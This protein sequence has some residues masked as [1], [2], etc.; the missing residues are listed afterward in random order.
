[1]TAPTPTGTVITTLEHMRALSPN[2][3]VVD[4]D[5]DPWQFDDYTL[6]AQPP[7]HGCTSVDF[8]ERYGPFI[9][10]YVPGRPAPRPS[11]LVAADAMRAALSVLE[12]YAMRMDTA[13][14]HRCNCN[15]FSNA[16]SAVSGVA[17]RLAA[18]ATTNDDTVTLPTPTPPMPF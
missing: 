1:M 11:A 8:V 17:E 7:P 15:C 12:G 13:Y 6:V 2:T 10:L 18:A 5:G 14:H 16:R 4:K 3:I 9:V